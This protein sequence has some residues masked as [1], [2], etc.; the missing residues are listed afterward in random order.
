MDLRKSNIMTHE[1][2]EFQLMKSND[3]NPHIISAS[4]DMRLAYPRGDND[5]VITGQWV[6]GDLSGVKI[7]Q[8]VKII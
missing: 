1:I 4:S 5:D 2:P 7:F 8:A 6:P 3:Q